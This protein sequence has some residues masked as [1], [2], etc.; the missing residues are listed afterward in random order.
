MDRRPRA[1]SGEDAG[2]ASFADDLPDR[3]GERQP[4]PVG[5][6]ELLERNAA[7]RCR[8]SAPS[9]R[10]RGTEPTGGLP[11]TIRR[12]VDQVG[13][14]TDSMF[15][16]G[17]VNQAM[18]GPWPRAMPPLVLREAVV[19]LETDASADQFVD[20]RFDVG[21]R[22]VQHCASRGLVITLLLEII[23]PLPTFSRRSPLILGISSTGRPSVGRTHR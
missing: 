1:G 5:F 23:T 13:D 16:A 20:G 6:A 21:H 8:T 14:S 18:S 3:P 4:G 11:G 12:L 15:P 19:A 7:A 22:K 17:S 2:Q 9:P 10:S